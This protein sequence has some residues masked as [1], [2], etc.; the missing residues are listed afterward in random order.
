MH[1]LKVYTRVLQYFPTGDKTSGQVCYRDT[2]CRWRGHCR[3]GYDHQCLL[4]AL[5]VLNSLDGFRPGCTT[6]TQ[7]LYWSANSCVGGSGIVD[8]PVTISLSHATIQRI[9]KPT[10]LP[11]NFCPWFLRGLLAFFGLLILK[12]KT[13]K[14]FHVFVA[15][16]LLEWSF[17]C[18]NTD[19]PM[20][21]FA[22][23]G[24]HGHSQSFASSTTQNHAVL[25]WNNDEYWI[26][27]HADMHI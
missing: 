20:H 11:W 9:T 24:M 2:S 22:Y 6:P 25:T 23:T 19:L 5:V 3:W 8:R 17:Q 10:R 26:G 12:K 7:F 4:L 27:R 21:L 18:L 16:T 1:C 13:K 14:T 15:G